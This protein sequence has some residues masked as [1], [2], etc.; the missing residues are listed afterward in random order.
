MIEGEVE[1]DDI[2]HP[3]KYIDQGI[4]EP[5]VDFKVDNFYAN[6]GNRRRGYYCFFLS[7]MHEGKI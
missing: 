2:G 3:F 1:S 6:G 4:V 7:H 5:F